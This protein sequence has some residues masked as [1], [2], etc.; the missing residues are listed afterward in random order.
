MEFD[1]GEIQVDFPG[2]RHKVSVLIGTWAH[3]CAV[4]AI[5]LPTQRT[6]AILHGLI[7][8]F[9]HFGCVP[10]EV[11]WDNPKTVAVQIRRGRDRRRNE[12]YMALAS[13]Y[14]FASPREKLVSNAYQ[15]S[16]ESAKVTQVVYRQRLAG[17]GVALAFVEWGELSTKLQL[18]S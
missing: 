13:H 15:T 17:P 9:E 14:N 2:G 10:K 3:S 11:W 12:L 16:H 4:F 18:R 7:A 1:F 6:K 5:A 8:A